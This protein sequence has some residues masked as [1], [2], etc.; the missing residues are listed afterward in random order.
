MCKLQRGGGIVPQSWQ[1]QWISYPVLHRAMRIGG[2]RW[3]WHPS[4]QKMWDHVLLYC[5]VDVSMPQNVLKMLLQQTL[6]VLGSF[7]CS[8]RPPSWIWGPFCGKEGGAKVALPPSGW[9]GSTYGCEWQLCCA[10][11]EES[12]SVV[13]SLR[14]RRQVSNRQTLDV[15]KLCKLS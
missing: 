5:K 6:G 1:H 12:A 4:C 15:T 10:Y 7:Q 2:F 14:T 3:P 9:S 8:A 11:V 13:A